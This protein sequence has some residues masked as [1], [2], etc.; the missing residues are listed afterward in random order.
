MTTEEFD[1]Y[2][3]YNGTEIKYKGE[4]FKI[5]QVD[6]ID[7]D[8]STG[9]HPFDINYRNIE[10]IRTIFNNLTFKK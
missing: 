8:V 5:I 10:E 7:R 1:N 2:E 9:I 6:F 3:F 4:W